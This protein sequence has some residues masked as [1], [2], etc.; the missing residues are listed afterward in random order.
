MVLHGKVYN[1]GPYLMYHP[2]GSEILQSSLGRDGTKMFEKFH[3]WVNVQ[4]LIGP[5]LIGYLSK[6]ERRRGDEDEEK[7]GEKFLRGNESCQEIV[8][9]SAKVATT[10]TS[11]NEIEF[12]MPN[13]RPSK[14]QYI[15]SLL[16]KPDNDDDEE[17]IEDGLL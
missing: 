13:P 15:P 8:L 6:D 1:I 14:G 4:G 10:K 2:G 7:M 9:P 16:G 11:R 17:N 12:A 5:L 3:A